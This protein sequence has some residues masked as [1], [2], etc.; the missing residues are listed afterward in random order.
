MRKRLPF[1]ACALV[2]L[3]SL[4][5]YS[6]LAPERLA[7]NNLGKEN[8]NKTEMQ[9]KKAL[10]KDSLNLGAIYTY[11]WFYFTAANPK[12]NIDSASLLAHK[13]QQ[14]FSSF[15]KKDKEKN[16]RFPFDSLGLQKLRTYI[17]STAFNRAKQLNSVEA[18]SYF[19]N[20]YASSSQLSRAIELQEE[21]AFLDALK[22]NTYQSFQAYIN[23]YPQ[24]SRAEEASKRYEK[25][26]FESKTKDQKLNSYVHFL[27]EYPQTP[28][29][30]L[31]EQQIFEMSTASGEVK[32]LQ[33][34]LKINPSSA[35]AKQA[36]DFLYYF[37]KD[38]PFQLKTLL[39]DSL[40]N[41][42]ALEG[43]T[44]IPFWKN[45]TYSFLD[46]KG[47]EH[48]SNLTDSLDAD[49]LCDGFIGDILLTKNK[50]WS[51]AG[52][53]L[54]EN[55][56]DFE[57][58][59]FGFLLV[60]YASG[61][62]KIIHK[63][64]LI[65]LDEEAKLVGHH[66]LFS[67]NDGASL[68]TLT[69]RKLLS[70]NW[71]EVI[72]F[73][74]VIAFKDSQGFKLVSAANLGLHANAQPIL[75]TNYFDE[76]KSID[77]KYIWVKK[78]DQ[79]GLLD[80]NLQFVLPLTQQHIEKAGNTILIKSNKQ[81]KTFAKGK[82]GEPY[83]DLQLT[84]SWMLGKHLGQYHLTSRS[85]NKSTT[86]DSAYLLSFAAIGYRNDSTFVFVN[87]SRHYF[88]GLLEVTLLKNANVSYVM[89]SDQNNKIV[90]NENGEKLFSVQADNLE[91][92]SADYFTYQKR[93]KR[94][95]INKKGLIVPLPDFDAFGSA[96]TLGIPVLANKKFGLINRKNDRIIKPTYNR[97]L[98]AYNDK[99]IVAYKNDAYGFIG[100]DDKPIGKFEYDEIQYWND[101]VALV[102]HNFSW[103]FLD[104]SSFNFRLGKISEF[105]SF[106]NASEEHFLIY[107][108]DNFYGVLSNR[109]GVI[110][111]PTY[112]SIENLGNSEQPFY[113]T[114][115]YV[116]EAEI[117]IVI[118]YN[119]TGKQVRRQI[120]EEDEFEY[121]LCK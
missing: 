88:S 17:D 121:I 36:R 48:L 15:T 97:N 94:I 118:Y 23:T 75:Y 79:T 27:E 37:L 33:E 6:Q 9:V 106:K 99:L 7:W 53:L 62:T 69:G 49:I 22:E 28:F 66:F 72:S 96:T 13:A 65:C 81:I 43:Q 92:V 47:G 100:W 116:E 87:T 58:I 90:V 11:A 73:G 85:N 98:N 104:L 115:K 71:S 41:V 5:G 103:R 95:L 50:L 44:W 19:I 93:D 54:A 68:Y 46:M 112:T 107:K 83:D 120:Y 35:Y 30:K 110:L 3:L 111:E 10:R 119:Q 82:A 109:R 102:K 12:F 14:H 59:G 60:D 91:C 25:L 61:G 63:S 31:V 34:F 24:S 78:G 108:Q 117:H 84:E 32:A 39:T 20:N 105:V 101:S 26:L 86:M 1:F 76:V 80:L 51:R 77:E 45:G 114:D 38:Q 21:V 113:M 52:F 55:V 4:Q 89:V 74:D 57:D 18:Y 40:A 42:L 16:L 70:G 2:L 67:K 8:W 56:A 29:K 64:G